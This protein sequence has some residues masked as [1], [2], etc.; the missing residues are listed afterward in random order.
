M[1]CLTCCCHRCHYSYV[2]Y[3]AFGYCRIAKHKETGTICALKAM[4]KGYLLKKNQAKHAIC[5]RNLLRQCVL[6]TTLLSTAAPS[7]RC[8]VI[9][10]CDSCAP[11]VHRCNHSGV[12]KLYG[13]FQDESMIYL[14]LEFL[15]GGELFTLLG[16]KVRHRHRTALTAQQP[17]VGYR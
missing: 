16:Q 9:A 13:S 8:G 10:W 14:C 1:H 7:F 6:I 4:A 11:V 5:E 2:G 12:V 3:G 17:T 15:P